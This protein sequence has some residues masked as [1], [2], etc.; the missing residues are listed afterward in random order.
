MVTDFSD[1]L[2]DDGDDKAMNEKIAKEK[3]LK[4][5][6]KMKRYRQKRVAKEYLYKGWIIQKVVGSKR[7]YDKKGKLYANW[8]ATKE[9]FGFTFLWSTTEEGIKRQI[10]DDEKPGILNDYMNFLGL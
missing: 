7:Y 10:D 1:L 9:L 8:R 2:S 5:K 4:L 6:A 3:D